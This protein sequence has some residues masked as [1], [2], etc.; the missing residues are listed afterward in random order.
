[1]KIIL[2]GATGVL[3]SHIMYEILELFINTKIDG[4][5]F[6]IARNKGKNSA[7]DRINELLSSSY[8]PKIIKD[9]G[10]SKLH[11]YIEIIDVD[12]AV[13]QDTFSSKIND[14]YFIHSAGFVN[15][16]TDEKQREKIFEEN[17]KITKSLFHLFHPF[18]KKFIYIGTAFS[19]GNRK[20]LIDNDFHSLGFKPEHR[21]A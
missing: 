8:T 15:L 17:T 1:M 14:A 5:L 11:K 6:I 7:V 18:I 16:S 4:K 21:N 13:I 3:G 12:L 19:S 2:T 20:G 10:I 9:K